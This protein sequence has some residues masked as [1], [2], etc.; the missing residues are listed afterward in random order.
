MILTK[1]KQNEDIVIARIKFPLNIAVLTSSAGAA[2][3]QQAFGCFCV[4]VRS[5]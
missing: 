2:T 1:K 4:A 5:E 3:T